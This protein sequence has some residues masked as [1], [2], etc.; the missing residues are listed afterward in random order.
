MLQDGGFFLVN[1]DLDQGFSNYGS[2]SHLGSRNV[3][4]GSWT[5]LTWQIR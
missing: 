2:Q 3:I 4:L 1:G 5:K